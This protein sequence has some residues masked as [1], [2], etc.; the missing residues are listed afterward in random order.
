MFSSIR[1]INPNDIQLPKGYSIEVY[2]SN[3]TTPNSLFFDNNNKILIS[4]SGVSSGNGR[5]LKQTDSGFYVL[6]DNFNPPLTGITYYDDKIYVSHKGSVTVVYKDGNRRDIIQGLPSW[7]DFSNNK[8]AFSHDDKMYF[9]QGT[10]TNSGVVGNDNAA[11]VRNYPFFN[12]LPGENI[13]LNGKNFITD[14]FLSPISHEESKTGAFSPYGVSVSRGEFIKSVVKASGSILRSNTDG[15]NIELYAWGLR[16]PARLC[17]DKNNRL[18]C[19][20]N[21]M[22]ARGSRPIANA[23][24]EFQ[25]IKRGYWYG[26]PD[27]AGGLPVTIPQHRTNNNDRM[28]FLIKDHP[29]T[30]PKPYVLFEPGSNITGHAISYNYQYSIGDIYIAE[31]GNTS[32]NN[33]GRKVSRIDMKSRTVRPFAENIYLKRKNGGLK[34]PVDVVFGPD[35]AMYI[36]DYGMFDESNNYIPKTGLI[37][38]IV[39]KYTYSR[40]NT[41]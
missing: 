33:I 2:A 38:K 1:Y 13:T 6:A 17:F 24:D 19:S 9:G 14:N 7:G 36:V 18:F 3:L 31:F 30:P 15:S 26:W 16:N 40:S 5:I 10:A 11:W 20:N 35:N 12:D 29:M 4:E 28:S 22:E 25:Q 8:V 27:F 23:P 37:W 21:G 39:K 34:H 32:N 41:L